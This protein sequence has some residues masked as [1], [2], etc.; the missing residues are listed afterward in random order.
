MVR[1]NNYGL[2]LGILGIKRIPTSGERDPN[3]LF[4][5]NDPGAE[6]CMRGQ[7]AS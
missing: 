5:R 1:A 2:D 7:I 4:E 3:P 6:G